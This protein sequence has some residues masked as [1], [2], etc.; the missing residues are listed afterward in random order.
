MIASPEDLLER[1][2]RAIAECREQDLDEEQM[3]KRLLEV[4]PDFPPGWLAMGTARLKALELDAAEPLLWRALAGAPSN[5]GYYFP[6]MALYRERGEVL[7]AKC[8]GALAMWRV[9]FYAEIPEGIADAL[10]KYLPQLGDIVRD[11]KTY[12]ILAANS[13]EEIGEEPWPA[14]LLPYRLLNDVQRQ[15]DGGLDPEI[16]ANIRSNGAAC[17]PIFHAALREV[18][19]SQTS[20]LSIKAGS[21][22]IALLGEIGGVDLLEDFLFPEDSDPEC[23]WHAHW[24][25]RRLGQRFPAEA[26]ARLRAAAVAADPD[27]RVSIAQHF[28][29]LPE[30]PGARQAILDLLDGFAGFA[31]DQA[32][33]IL[34]QTVST[35]MAMMDAPGESLAV[36]KRHERHLSKAAGG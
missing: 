7:L 34:L 28:Y 15:A 32:A 35:L 9:S 29:F 31:S 36:L 17:A 21:L 1:R 18:N 14:Q 22:L 24:A 19:D 2:R 10:A 16:I 33:P 11:P 26:F 27:M 6:L 13:E 25:V 23:Y 4:D 30:T 20:S 5:P 8:L 12:E 3:A